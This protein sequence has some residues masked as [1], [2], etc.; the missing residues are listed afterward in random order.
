MNKHDKTYRQIREKTEEDRVIDSW[1]YT[2]CAILIVCFFLGMSL[3]DA[4]AC[5]RECARQRQFQF[6]TDQQYKQQIQQQQIQDMRNAQIQQDLE[7]YR[8]IIPGERRLNY[9][10]LNSQINRPH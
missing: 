5:D 6:Q 2:I 4:Q 9:A 10:P 7:S 3:K 8:V 1:I